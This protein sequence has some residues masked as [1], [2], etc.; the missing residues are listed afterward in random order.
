LN[1]LQKERLVLSFS[2]SLMLEELDSSLAAGFISKIQYD[3]FKERL[4]YP[5]TATYDYLIRQ[6][7]I[8]SRN[9]L[10]KC[11]TR[12]S[13]LLFWEP[14]MS[15]GHKLYLSKYDAS[16]LYIKA[17]EYSN[18]F[19]CLTIHNALQLCLSMKLERV[20]KAKQIL[21]E[22]NCEILSNKIKFP[23][24]PERH[25]VQY[26][27]D[28]V[29]L[30]ISRS[31]DI[32]YLRKMSAD[33][34]RIRYY[35]R[36][37]YNFLNHNKL[38]IFN[39]DETQLNAARK[40]KVLVERNKLTLVT[41]D[42]K[43]PHIT[44]III[45]GAKGIVLKPVIIL[46]NIQKIKSLNQFSEECCFTTSSNGWITKNLFL[47]FAFHFC[48]EV[49]NYR[50]Q[51]P[52]DLQHNKILLILDNHSSRFNLWAVLVFRY[53]GVDAVLL[54]SHTTHFMSAFDVAVVSPLKIAFKEQLHELLKKIS[55]EDLS[56]RGK[57]E[58]LRFTLVEAFL[59]ALS[60]GA[61][62]K[63]IKSG[64]SATGISPLDP[65]KPL[66]SKYIRENN[67][68][69]F[70]ESEEYIPENFKTSLLTSDESIQE[71]A[72][73][74]L[75]RELSDEEINNFNPSVVYQKMMKQSVIYGKPLSPIS[76]IHV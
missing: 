40:F 39:A 34:D 49:S 53:F 44:G 4:L 73:F 8:P 11:I 67:L 22:M 10:C 35:F 46:K 47:Y 13:L 58:K 68:S 30:R 23:I 38:L 1:S 56:R 66:A 17:I 36:V 65:S 16:Q 76:E 29:G 6:F 14:G 69:D 2:Y 25:W 45:I 41:A 26:F 31:Q 75:K 3:C 62:R 64:F 71:L 48:Q 57:S 74:E 5:I 60:I 12:T 24:S 70:K 55:Q 27:V 32:E 20:L 15:G 19:D 7:Q 54:P 37:F 61:H 63:N 50:I 51:L 33:S 42:T 18:S 9:V 28:R 72:M 21:L 43:V 59:N 52:V